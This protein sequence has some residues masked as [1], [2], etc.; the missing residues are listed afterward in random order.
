LLLENI[1]T[2]SGLPTVAK[3]EAE[4]KSIPVTET[5]CEKVAAVR[6]FWLCA[7]WMKR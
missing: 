4:Y 1:F 7:S 3:L 2:M 5:D 6:K